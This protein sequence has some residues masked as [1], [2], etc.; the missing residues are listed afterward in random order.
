MTKIGD[1]V[2]THVSRMPYGASLPVNK[3]N[4]IK[5]GGRPV[6]FLPDIKR[7]PI[8]PVL[9]TVGDDIRVGAGSKLLTRP[10]VLELS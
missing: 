10:I 9:R 8:W 3:S 4:F 2:K 5:Y 1:V 6:V 7:Q